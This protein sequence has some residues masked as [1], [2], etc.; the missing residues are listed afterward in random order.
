M[1][2]K[3]RSAFG[4]KRSIPSDLRIE[5]QEAD[6]KKWANKSPINSLSIELT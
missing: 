1:R 5:D 2:I 3:V 4:Q 6:L